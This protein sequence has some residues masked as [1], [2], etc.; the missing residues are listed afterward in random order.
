MQHRRRGCTLH[1]D[2]LRITAE[3]RAEMWKASVYDRNEN[4]TVY[5]AERMRAEDAMRDA[6]AFSVRRLFGSSSGFSPGLLVHML[7]WKWFG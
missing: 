6:V 2:A 7:P 5:Q 1:W 4:A 3:K